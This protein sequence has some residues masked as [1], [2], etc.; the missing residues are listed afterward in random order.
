MENQIVCPKCKKTLSDNP[1]INQA[2]KGEGSFTQSMRCECGER[3]TYWQITAQLRA[4][5]TFVKRFKNWIR[6]FS[7]SRS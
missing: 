7:H 3:V 5:K 6:S 4:Q 1:I 2:I